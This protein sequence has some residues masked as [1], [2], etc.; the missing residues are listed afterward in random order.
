MVT[1]V[2]LGKLLLIELQE[3]VGDRR[4]GTVREVISELDKFNGDQNVEEVRDLTVRRAS[5]LHETVAASSLKRGVFSQFCY[6]LGFQA[7]FADRRV[8]CPILKTGES[9]NLS[10][11]AYLTSSGRGVVGM[12]KVAGNQ[13][14]KGKIPLALV[15]F[16]TFK[17]N[18]G[19]K[20]VPKRSLFA[21][22]RVQHTLTD[23]R[24]DWNREL[25][26]ELGRGRFRGPFS[27]WQ[28]P[29]STRRLHPYRVQ[30]FI[31]R[32]HQREEG[33]TEKIEGQSAQSE[34]TAILRQ[35]LDGE[36]LFFT[37]AQ[38]L[39]SPFAQGSHQGVEKEVPD[40][41]CGGGNCEYGN[42]GYQYRRWSHFSTFLCRV[43]K[44]ATQGMTIHAWGGVAPNP[45]PLSEQIRHIRHCKPALQDGKK[46]KC[47]LLMKVFFQI[48]LH[49]DIGQ[50]Y[51][52]SM[53][54]GALSPEFVRSHSG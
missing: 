10:A 21:M 30:V 45:L 51:A 18:P 20:A 3:N 16:G 29:W 5:G 12:G 25:I 8:L 7:K 27:K 38:E 52:V 14:H 22:I 33:M 54:D 23:F 9:I 53:V 34:Q 46:P 35:I 26:R 4:G 48:A 19:H 31:I 42:G 2:A 28:Q 36:N 32:P 6:A 11:L 15:P 41:G 1:E 50:P 24:M 40:G 49:R 17:D 44:P 43:L 47:L 39:E 13:S 37:V